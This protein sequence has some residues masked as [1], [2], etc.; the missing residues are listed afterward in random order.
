[1]KRKTLSLLLLS[2][3]LVLLSSIPVQATNGS[4]TYVLGICIDGS[5]SIPSWD[6]SIMIDSIADSVR[7]NLPH[8]GSVELCVIQFSSGSPNA[9][10]EVAPTVIDSD[11]TAETIAT[12]IE[13]IVQ[14][15]LNTAT[16]DGVWLTW[17]TMK[18]ASTF[19]TSDKQIIHLI[20]DG[21]PNVPL[22]YD[23]STGNPSADV[24]AVVEWAF[25]FEGLDE[26]NA[27]AVGC[28]VSVVEWLRDYIV[29]PVGYQAPTANANPYDYDGDD[30]YDPGWVYVCDDFEEFADTICE[31]FEAMLH[32]E[33]D[34]AAV[35]QTVTGNTVEQGELVDIDVTVQNN[36]DVTETFDVRCTYDSM[37]IGTKTVTNLAPGASTV[38]TFTWDTTGVPLNGYA[39]TAHADSGETIDE[40][41]ED[42]NFCY[43]PLNI[44]VVPESPL[45]TLLV[46]FCMFFAF[47]GYTCSK[48]YRKK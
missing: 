45:G 17:N 40:T 24:Y 42:N 12:T 21:E 41:D 22:T 6:F 39:I 47:V 25:K 29:R 2:F 34:V 3:L 5:G 14:I 32:V 48:R 10:V 33:H 7:N 16:A 4:A 8:D 31:N 43:M 1:M 15:Q 38:V 46:P 23:V 37:E 9:R 44:F 28:V 19:A 13:N 11:A 18:G 27:A 20:T 36:G 26:V 30:N 35:S